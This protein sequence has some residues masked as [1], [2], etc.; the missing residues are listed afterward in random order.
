M[1]V[2]ASG[3]PIATG[4]GQPNSSSARVF[5]AMIVPSASNE[6][7]ASCAVSM[8]ATLS[9]SWVRLASRSSRSSRAVRTYACIISS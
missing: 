2:R 8:T 4:A 1:I 9:A 3:R 5:Q 6:T 7:N